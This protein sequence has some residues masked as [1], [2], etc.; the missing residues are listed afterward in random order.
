MKLNEIE[1]KTI[2]NNEQFHKLQKL[3]LNKGGAWID[4]D[5]NFINE[6]DEYI[7]LFLSDGEMSTLNTN[8]NIYE[9]CNTD[10]PNMSFHEITHIL[11][12]IDDKIKEDKYKLIDFDIDDQG[13][14]RVDISTPWEEH[15]KF[16]KYH[17]TDFHEFEKDTLYLFLFAGFGYVTSDDEIICLPTRENKNFKNELYHGLNSEKAKGPAIP[18][19]IY[20]WSKL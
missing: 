5:K 18:I 4:S 9:Y 15:E 14:F 12:Q 2:C 17:W 20:F 6:T 16:K 3:I 7:C 19:K 13:F 11:N 8:E 10:E 1:F